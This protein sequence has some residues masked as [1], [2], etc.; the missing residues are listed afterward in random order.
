[1]PVSLIPRMLQ[2]LSIE[3]PRIYS[4]PRF[5]FYW[6]FEPP[7]RGFTFVGL[8]VCSK[9]PQFLT[10]ILV[11]NFFPLPGANGWCFERRLHSPLVEP[12]RASTG[13]VAA[14]KPQA[15]CKSSPKIFSMGRIAQDK[16]RSA[17]SPAAL[18]SAAS[19]PLPPFTLCQN[20]ASWRTTPVSTSPE[21]VGAGY[22]AK[23]Y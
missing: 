21:G 12:H 11:S 7:K 3:P 8:A 16:R 19:S 22:P 10:H 20:P 1:M 9:K 6:N 23:W 4:P 13:W 14:T 17:E 15:E 5:T 2:P 18:L